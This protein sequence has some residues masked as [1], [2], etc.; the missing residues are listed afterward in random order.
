MHSTVSCTRTTPRSSPRLGT[1]RGSPSTSVSVISSWRNGLMA[2]RFLWV[3]I[4]STLF[5]DL[6]NISSWVRRRSGGPRDDVQQHWDPAEP[7]HEKAYQTWAL[8]SD[9]EGEAGKLRVPEHLLRQAQPSPRIRPSGLPM[10]KMVI[11]KTFPSQ[12]SNVSF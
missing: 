2:E 1:W 11:T 7:R 10:N 5:G 6:L 3:R 8:R 12:Y 9:Q 4:F